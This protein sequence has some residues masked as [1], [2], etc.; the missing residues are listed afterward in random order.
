MF[1]VLV[2]EDD[3]EIQLVL[4]NYLEE[5]GYAV[6]LAQDGVE[7][8]AAFREKE[9][10]LILLDVMLPKIDGFAVLERVS[11]SGA[12]GDGQRQRGGSNPRV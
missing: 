1:E 11:G 10:D 2:I 4:K 12:H 5:E 7:G 8:L 3:K 6:R 9:A